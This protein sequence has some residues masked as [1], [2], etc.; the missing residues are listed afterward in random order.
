M[1]MKPDQKDWMEATATQYTFIDKPSLVWNVHV[2]M[3]SFIFL[4]G[5]DKFTKGKGEMLIKMNSLIPVVDEKG[6]KIDEGSIQR[7]LGEMVWFPSLA[8]SPY[9]NWEEIDD[10][11]AKATM[12]YMGTK[13]SGVFHFNSEG[14]FTKFS[15]M[16]FK[17]N[18]ETSKRYEW[19][20]LVQNYSEFEGIRV[21]SEMTA[22]WKLEDGDWTWLE[23][24]I[25]DIKY[26]K[27]ALE[28]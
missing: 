9:V 4:L 18:D 12:E 10:N 17:D 26:N 22:T 16:R 6:S 11:S 5:R 2:K 23:L 7:Y 1:K 20:L 15:A 28:N 8:L 14:D 25:Q 21:P 13:G 19:V 3:N 27:N 24:K